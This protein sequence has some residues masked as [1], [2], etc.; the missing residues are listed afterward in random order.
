MLKNFRTI[1]ALAF[2]LS[3]N[4][5]GRA[6]S[7]PT[8]SALGYLQVGVGYT[9]V[10]PDYGT[11]SIAGISGFGDFD[12]RQ[13]VGVE[14]TFHYASLTTPTNLGENTYLIGPRLVLPRER[15]SFYAKALFG[16]G[17]LNNQ[18]PQ[19]NPGV[20]GNYFAYTAGGGVD[21]LV[22][23][24]VVVRAIDLEYQHWDYLT[25]LTPLAVSVGAAYRF[26]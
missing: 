20:G 1:G 22:R 10:K 21:V 23:N 19:F 12:I 14:A 4:C 15:V 9:Y 25:G 16:I 2:L 17:V 5:L 11:Q 7:L 6:Q 8:A 24:H 18:A 26:R 3:L 13:H